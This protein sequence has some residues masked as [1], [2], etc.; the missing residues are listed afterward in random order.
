M[1]AVAPST[2]LPT[3][4]GRPYLTPKDAARFLD[5]SVTHLEFLRRKRQGPPHTNIVRSVR[6]SVADLIA[7]LEARKVNTGGAEGGAA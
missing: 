4:E 7:W 3:F 6:Y 5:L 2:S 1:P